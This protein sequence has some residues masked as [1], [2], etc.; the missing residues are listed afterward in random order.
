MR[1]V[2]AGVFFKQAGGQTL[3]LIARR[4]Q[5]HGNPAMRGL[6]E[7]PGGKQE[8]GET[9]FQC[10]EREIK[11]ELCVNCK[12]G[13]III[14]VPYTYNFG[15]I[16]L[17]AIRAELLSDDHDAELDIK[18]TVHDALEWVPLNQLKDYKFPPADEAV[19]RA[20]ARS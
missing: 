19:I 9:I 8:A 13:P 18:L 17:V 2:A 16:N 11:E 5:S 14:E 3:V 20:L 12:A 1:N 10:L 7:F 6:W 4:N 15:S